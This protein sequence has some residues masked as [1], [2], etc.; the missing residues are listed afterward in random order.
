MVLMK[1]SA[2]AL[3]PSAVCLVAAT[4]MTG[5]CSPLRVFGPVRGTSAGTVGRLGGGV[6]V[7]EALPG[8]REEVTGATVVCGALSV[9]SGAADDD[10]QAAMTAR[11]PATQ[12]ARNV[13][14]VALARTSS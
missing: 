13:V 6:E 1:N 12:A 10:V 5:G 4:G 8:D 9:G 14:I 3:A 2:K 11:Q 7:V